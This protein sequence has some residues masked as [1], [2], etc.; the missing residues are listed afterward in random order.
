M[1]QQDAGTSSPDRGHI[2]RP[3]IMTPRLIICSL[4]LTVTSASATTPLTT[5]QSVTAVPAPEPGM[6][7]S[8]APL[9]APGAPR[10]PTPKLAD[11]RT[12]LETGQ[13]DRALRTAARM[14]KESRWGRD[15][16][17]A[18]LALG[19][20]YR[21]RE[22]HNLASEAFTTVRLSKTPLSE[23]GAY[24]EAEQDF[25]RGRPWV[26][27]QECEKY[28]TNWPNGRFDGACRRLSARALVDSGRTS[29]ARQTALDYDE[30]FPDNAIEE[31][32]DLAVARRWMT[33]H[34]IESRDMLRRLSV[35]HNLPL[36]G[37]LAEESLAELKAAGVPHAEVPTDSDSLK[38][39]AVSLREAKRKTEAWST[40]Q[41]LVKRSA[42]DPSLAR[43]VE[44]E[45]ARF[46]WRT[47][48]WDF[49]ADYYAKKYAEK[50]T[51]EHA[52]NAYRVRDRGGRYA[53]AAKWIVIGQSKHSKTK[54]WR[55]RHESTARTYML[56]KDYNNARAQFDIAGKQGRWS[57]RRSRL[58]AGF[59]SYMN[60]D[61]EDA[62]KRLSKTVDERKGYLPHA[63][64]WRAKALDKL[65]RADEA[66]A[67]RKWIQETEPR[68]WY[69]LLLRQNARESKGAPWDRTGRWADIPPQSFVDLP[70]TDRLAESPIAMWAGPGL[71]RQDLSPW[72]LLTW[73]I[74]S[75]APP[76]ITPQPVAS[77]PTS[78]A[79]RDP[80][81]PAPSY[82]T[83]QFHDPDAAR[84]A[85]DRMAS[86]HGDRWPEWSTVRDLANAGLYDLS[87]PM[88]SELYEEW[89]EAWRSS[90]H[91][92]HA[93]ARRISSQHDDWRLLF[94]AARDHHHTDRFT[95]GLWDTVSDV[96]E[97]KKA[98]ELGW[99]L[100]H[101]RY[102]WKH[103]RDNDVDPYLVMAVM[104]I[105]SRYDAIARSRVGAR[106]AMQIMPRTG[107]LIADLRHEPEF[108]N[109]DLEDPIFAVGYGIFY[110]GTLM[111]RFDGAYPLAV[112]SYNGGPFNTS[113]WL[114]GAGDLPMDEF[115]EHI[116][117]RETR[118]YVRSVSAAYETYVNLYGDSGTQLLI[119]D[120]PF[121]DDP[122]RVDF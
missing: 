37:R 103:S 52:W 97:Q 59:A 88:M 25:K 18:A 111:D 109:G 83:S 113:A 21:E 101:D 49:L 72:S 69:A 45:E 9:T 11:L 71:P 51:G 33:S 65:Q 28:A 26:A 67:D 47:H 32:I 40:F 35:E 68:G 22:L 105:E 13:D 43:W 114:K 92:H 53:D 106:G 50:P 99:P 12:L 75:T 115:V 74:Q 60:K 14:V 58:Y 34:P 31:Q 120:G 93:S 77:G 100:A 57:G 63:R 76:S 6:V 104:R 66:S 27:V 90:R 95:F 42:E 56:L 55:R 8:E 3:F 102:V 89:R 96:T 5:A 7:L 39:R 24:F 118:R 122:L 2:S 116:P 121:A 23:W 1:P 117:F 46:G 64:Y 80:L 48:Q 17:V 84:R 110:L 16:T 4:L 15:R 54:W 108:T 30:E 61:Y 94:Y 119:P 29:A 70:R 87:G 10:S 19:M 98:L 86:K 41:V 82:R 73:P 81:A 36:T 20:M 78:S 91:P 79:F 62:I 112:A 38:T 85:L 44:G 107:A